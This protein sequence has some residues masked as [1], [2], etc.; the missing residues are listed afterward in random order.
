MFSVP[1]RQALEQLTPAAIVAE[2]QEHMLRCEVAVSILSSA[3]DSRAPTEIRAVNQAP[4]SWNATDPAANRHAVV[5]VEAPTS[6]PLPAFTANPSALRFI[7]SPG[8]TW[9]DPPSE[10]VPAMVEHSASEILARLELEGE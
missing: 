7:V 8:L 3:A 5:V 6:T 9:S 4:T 1:V 10:T 2:L